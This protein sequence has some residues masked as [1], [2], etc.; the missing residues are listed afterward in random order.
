MDI[1]WLAGRYNSTNGHFLVIPT[2]EEMKVAA[3]LTLLV[4]QLLLSCSRNKLGN[5]LIIPIMW[6]HINIILII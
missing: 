3:T 5:P 1:S 2:R 4:T 6:N